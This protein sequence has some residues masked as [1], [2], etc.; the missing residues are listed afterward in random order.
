MHVSYENKVT[1]DNKP[2]NACV[3]KDVLMIYEKK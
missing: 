3:L 1:D 2:L